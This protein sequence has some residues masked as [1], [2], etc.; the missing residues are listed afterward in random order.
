[1]RVQKLSFSPHTFHQ[2]KNFCHQPF[3]ICKH[4]SSLLLSL[5]WNV[6]FT[7]LHCT[8]REQY[9]YSS[10]W[11]S[12]PYTIPN[13]WMFQS[14]TKWLLRYIQSFLDCFSRFASY[15]FHSFLISHFH[16][17]ITLFTNIVYRFRCSIC[18]F[19]SI[20]ITISIS[21]VITQTIM[22]F[23]FGD[24][25]SFVNVIHIKLDCSYHFR[26]AKIEF[27]ITQ[28]CMYKITKCQVK[29][30]TNRKF[31]QNGIS[32]FSL[33]SQQIHI[34]HWTELNWTELMN[35]W[36]FRNFF[37]ICHFLWPTYFVRAYWTHNI[38]FFSIS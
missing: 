14:K 29:Q 17:P 26:G 34:E 4:S 38:S 1:M 35:N 11:Y 2:L 20:S 15:Q 18:C 23:D 8:E 19:I 7:Q 37:F 27:Q 24:Y 30:I 28:V 9:R 33:Q 22:A 36:N 6:Q 32:Q 31:I 16:L 5:L 10:V 12:R 25:I 13:S 21:I 3:G